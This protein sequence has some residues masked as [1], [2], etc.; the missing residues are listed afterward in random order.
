MKHLSR[1][2]A[3]EFKKGDLVLRKVGEAKMDN[4]LVPR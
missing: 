4:K 2:H 3:K 1:V